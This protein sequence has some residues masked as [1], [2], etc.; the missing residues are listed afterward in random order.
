MNGIHN[1]SPFH[2]EKRIIEDIL[3]LFYENSW[4]ISTISI[5]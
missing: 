1:Y 5:A 4:L 2:I 3:L